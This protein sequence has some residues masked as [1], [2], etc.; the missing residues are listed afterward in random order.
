MRVYMCDRCETGVLVPRSKRDTIFTVFYSHRTNVDEQ[1][2]EKERRRE[3]IL[4]VTFQSF[5]IY[6]EE[7]IDWCFESWEP[8]SRENERISLIAIALVILKSFKS[9]ASFRKSHGSVFLDSWTPRCFALNHEDD[10]GD[11]RFSWIIYFKGVEPTIRET[12]CARNAN[13]TLLPIVL[14]RDTDWS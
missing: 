13:E 4:P 9:L 12:N 2:D 3:T 10:S 1:V 8:I 7:R 6:R 14:P 11:E 5:Q